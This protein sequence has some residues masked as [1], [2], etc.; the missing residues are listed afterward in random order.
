MSVTVLALLN[1]ANIAKL[2]LNA[3]LFR[4]RPVSKR[5]L[6]VDWFFGMVLNLAGPAERL[7]LV[8]LLSIM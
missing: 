3:T 8:F 6:Y 2:P 7:V 5:F 4:S 1:H